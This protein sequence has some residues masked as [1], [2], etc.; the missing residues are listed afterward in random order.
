M[1]LTV[2]RVRWQIELL[3]K[4][5][6]SHINLDKLKGKTNPFRVLCELYTKLCA[7]LVFH[8]MITKLKKNTV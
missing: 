1:L 4:L 3:F 8:G 2:Y 5:Y 6:K 7:I